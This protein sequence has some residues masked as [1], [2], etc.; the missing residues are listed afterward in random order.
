MYFCE[1]EWVNRKMG[2][3][4]SYSGLRIY[5]YGGGAEAGLAKSTK[6][7]KNTHEAGRPILSAP[8]RQ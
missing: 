8:P 4:T 5:V 7:A 2:R 6:I 1:N 3:S